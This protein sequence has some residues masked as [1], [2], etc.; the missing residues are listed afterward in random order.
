MINLTEAMT[1]GFMKLHDGELL[2]EFMSDKERNRAYRQIKRII[3]KENGGHLTKEEIEKLTWAFVDMT[4][5]EFGW[6]WEEGPIESDYLYDTIDSWGY[7]EEAK[8]SDRPE[9]IVATLGRKWSEGPD[10]DKDDLEESMT[11][12]IDEEEVTYRM[13]DGVKHKIIKVKD[14]EEIKR[15]EP[16]TM[17][18]D[19]RLKKQ[20]EIVDPFL[21]DETNYEDIKATEGTT[22]F[23]EEVAK[24]V[25][26][27][28]GLKE[29]SYT[30]DYDYLYVKKVLIP[31]EEF[32][33]MTDQSN[34]E[35][36]YVTPDGKEYVVDES[37][38]AISL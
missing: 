31:K 6:D 11:E 22:R 23:G 18:F 38:F 33:E 15:Y 37:E 24:K 20:E 10:W 26:A 2:N 32:D 36:V 3:V 29:D 1:E 27:L 4:D 8:T 7:D 35:N 30:S 5:D 14:I 12:A 19:E 9:D 17:T 34:V 25:A 16:Y 13:D 28:L 21:E